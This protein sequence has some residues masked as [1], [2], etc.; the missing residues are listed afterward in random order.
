MK[1]IY[2]I[3]IVLIWL[4]LFL[5]NDISQ[6]IIALLTTLVLLKLLKGEK[7]GRSK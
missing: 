7:N 4:N 3:L 2:I 1:T 5:G 6:G